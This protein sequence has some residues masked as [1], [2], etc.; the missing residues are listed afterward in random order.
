[1]KIMVE[2]KDLM[3]ILMKYRDHPMTISYD[4]RYRK[5][6]TVDID[7]DPDDSIAF[8]EERKCPECEGSGEYHDQHGGWSEVGYCARCEG[9]GIV[10][11]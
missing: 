2:E 8:G 6:W 4:K 1:M 3:V 5:G 9:K 7:M 11:V 10:K